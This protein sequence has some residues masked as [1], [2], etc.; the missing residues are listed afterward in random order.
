MINNDYK[1][2]I[3][4]ILTEIL[5]YDEELITTKALFGGSGICYKDIIFG[6]FYNDQFYLRGHP[7]YLTMM[8]ELKMEP[9]ILEVGVR[10]KLLQY[11]QVTKELWQNEDK[12][13]KIIQM[14]VEIS[15][16]EKI[17]KRQIREARIKDL[18]NMTLSLERILFKA[19]VI[20]IDLLRQLGPFKVYYKLQQQ[21]KHISK[22]IL[23]SLYCALEGVHVAILTEEKRCQLMEEY[24]SFINKKNNE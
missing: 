10:N 24:N 9:L 12:L 1:N 5:Q 19:G 23:F 15:Q 20:N 16:Q 3:I 6:W 11:Y 8:I 13:I 2:I 22:N 17:S 4:R 21:N 18:P 14:V 7:D